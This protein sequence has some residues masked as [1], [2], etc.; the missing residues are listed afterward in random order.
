MVDLSS[1]PSDITPENFFTEVLPEVLGDVELPSGLGTERM[2]FN[3][4]GDGGA[5]Y[6]IGID[7]D[8]DLT[9]EEGQA[10]T[11]P[12]AVTA[13]MDAFRSILAG[14]LRDRILSATGA[15][16]IGPKQ[17]RKAFMPDA[18]VQ[19][20]KAI[21]GD[22][23]IRIEDGGDV[24]AVTT[25]FG[26]G[27]P[28]TTTPVCRVSIGVPSILEIAQKKANPQQLFMQGKIR[29]EG[30]MNIV[31]QLMGILSAPN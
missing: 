12:I 27:T 6:H 8:G 25:T 14:D 31:F 20:V 5:S 18:K 3:I 13:S 1:L 29:I 15:V 21:K 2:Q 23:Q 17:L 10:G 7:G 19:K 28:N 16:M 4:T 26:G 30:D 9:I 22:V 11:P 24:T